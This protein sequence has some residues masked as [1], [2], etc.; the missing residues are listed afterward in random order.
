MR[1]KILIIWLIATSLGYAQITF[2]GCDNLFDMQTFTF[3]NLGDDGNGRNSFETEP[4]IGDQPCSGVGTCEFRIVWNN[5]AMQWEFLAD[6][7]NGGFSATKLIYSNSEASMPNPPSLTLGTWVEETAIT[8]GDCGGNLT[9][10]NST[11]NGDVQNNVLDTDDFSA[12]NSLLVYPNPT[13]GTLYLEGVRAG[14]INTVSLYDISGKLILK[15]T[16]FKKEMDLSKL[17]TGV[18]FLKLETDYG[19]VER[20]IIIQ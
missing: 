8:S 3:N 6:D 5:T 2:T 16:V 7:G 10:S 18:Y 20:K 4:I 9:T 11:M 17:R 15:R 12:E 19:S 1:H 14:D 13:K